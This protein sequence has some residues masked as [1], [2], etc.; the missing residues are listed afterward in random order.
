[1]RVVIYTTIMIRDVKFQSLIEK[2]PSY[3]EDTIW[4]LFT[5]DFF[6][7]HLE[8]SNYYLPASVFS[9]TPQE[10]FCQYSGAGSVNA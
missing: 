10:R 1:M 5:G 9:L 6:T 7:L 3:R 8:T 2:G 4:F